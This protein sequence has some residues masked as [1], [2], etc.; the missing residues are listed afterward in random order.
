M[1]IIHESRTASENRGVLKFFYCFSVRFAST[2]GSTK[3]VAAMAV[4]VVPTPT[5]LNCRRS[6]VFGAFV[7]L[8]SPYGAADSSLSQV[9]RCVGEL[10]GQCRRKLKLRC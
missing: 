3:L 2:T 1:K 7:L 8:V 5:A 9:A 10:E 4:P 6:E